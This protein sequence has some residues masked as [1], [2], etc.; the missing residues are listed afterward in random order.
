MIETFE[1]GKWWTISLLL[2]IERPAYACYFCLY[3]MQARPRIKFLIYRV[4]THHSYIKLF[5]LH[6]SLT[7]YCSLNNVLLLI[8][9]LLIMLMVCHH[10]L[11]VTWVFS[12]TS[13]SLSHLFMIFYSQHL[14]WDRWIRGFVLSESSDVFGRCACLPGSATNCEDTVVDKKGYNT[15]VSIVCVDALITYLCIPQCNEYLTSTLHL[16]GDW[17]W[18]MCTANTIYHVGW[19]ASWILMDQC[20]FNLQGAVKN[21]LPLKEVLLECYFRLHWVHEHL[22]CTVRRNVGI[23]CLACLCT[24]STPEGCILQP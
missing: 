5:A 3:T 17:L 20:I 11:C 8:L 24:S 14:S 13:V 2:A 9:R 12:G 10:R 19:N 1:L 16:K 4:E 22:V 23:V 18:Y 21:V 6:L 7:S 15:R